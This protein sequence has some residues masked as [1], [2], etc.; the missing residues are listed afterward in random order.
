[1]F[2]IGFRIISF[3]IFN[4][5]EDSG[6][7]SHG[8]EQSIPLRAVGKPHESFSA[9]CWSVSD[10][11]GGQKH[12]HLIWHWNFS[13]WQKKTDWLTDWSCLSII[14]IRTS[15][16]HQW[17]GG[18]DWRRLVAL[19]PEEVS[20]FF[21]LLLMTWILSATTKHLLTSCDGCKRVFRRL[22]TFAYHWTDKSL[23]HQHASPYIL[24][25]ISDIQN[26]IVV[27]YS[28]VQCFRTPRQLTPRNPQGNLSFL[29]FLNIGR[30]SL[31][32]RQRRWIVARRK[33]SKP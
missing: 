8:N 21:L 1:M 19:H 5:S 23:R 13:T 7:D 18:C 33:K 20:L 17:T 25:H 28:S 22:P 26:A 14:S 4:R 10:G 15:F 24:I 6:W 12:H 3:D 2:L 29:F 16:E 11:I 31:R 9:F 27:T 30:K 32:D